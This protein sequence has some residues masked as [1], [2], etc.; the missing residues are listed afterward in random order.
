M[1]QLRRVN[2]QNIQIAQYQT[3]NPIKKIGGKP[4]YTFPQR[5]HT[6]TNRHMKG[7]SA[8]LIILWWWF[9]C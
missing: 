3:N 9:D 7:C 4:K 5:A 8:S 1:N 6:M 2:V